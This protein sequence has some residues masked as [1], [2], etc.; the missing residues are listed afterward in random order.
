MDEVEVEVVC[1]EVGERPLDGSL[2]PLPTVVGRR[3]LRR[4]YRLSILELC[5]F[6]RFVYIV[7]VVPDA[8]LKV[9]FE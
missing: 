3:Q 5:T 1:L 8:S 9:V 4:S 6:E 7:K 2:S